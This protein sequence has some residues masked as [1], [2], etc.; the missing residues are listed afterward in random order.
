MTI[1]LDHTIVPARDANAAARQLAELLD[2]P[3]GPAA[4]GPFVAV[5]LNEGLTLDFISTD[6]DFP[7]YHFAFRVTPGDFAAILARIQAAGLAYRSA[8]RGPDDRM[9]NTAIGGQMIY[10]NEPAGHQWEILTESYARQ[11]R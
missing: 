11:A 10:W 7:V 1:H 5:Y 3:W 4:A 8:V 2:V 9:V 6:E